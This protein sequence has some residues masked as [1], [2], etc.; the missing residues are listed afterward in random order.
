MSYAKQGQPYTDDEVALMYKLANTM[1]YKN[2]AQYFNRSASSIKRQFNKLGIRNDL[3]SNYKRL[4][5]LNDSVFNEITPESSYWAGLLAAD[6]CLKKHGRAFSIELQ[7]KDELHLGKLLEYLESD[8]CVGYRSIKEMDGRNLYASLNVT[9]TEI[10]EALKSNF[11]LKPKKSLDLEPP[12]IKE[13]K[14]REAF[15]LGLFDGDGNIS[16]TVDGQLVAGFTTASKNMALW[17]LEEV[18]RILGK[19]EH[20]ITTRKNEK[21]NEYYHIPLHTLEASRFLAKLYSAVELG[22]VRKFRIY[23]AQ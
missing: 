4:T 12:I 6:G 15:M 20:P 5:T 3:R 14:C 13:I 1:S 8:G 9:S 23:D 22:L 21:G 7:A 19:S 17:F 16:R 2:M 18:K 11:N 10:I